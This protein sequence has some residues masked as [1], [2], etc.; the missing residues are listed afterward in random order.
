MAED[1]M[2]EQLLTLILTTCTVVLARWAAPVI[3]LNFVG[4]YLIHYNTEVTNLGENN[5]CDVLN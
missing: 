1:K 2:A 5:K 4:V 3:I